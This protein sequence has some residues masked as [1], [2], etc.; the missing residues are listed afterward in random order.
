MVVSK[1]GQGFAYF[2]TFLG[3]YNLQIAY[4]KRISLKIAQ[5]LSELSNRV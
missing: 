2:S 1:G 4:F 5:L 3:F